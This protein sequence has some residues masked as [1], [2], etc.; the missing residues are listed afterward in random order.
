MLFFVAFKVTLFLSI[1]HYT[2]IIFPSIHI[3]LKPQPYTIYIMKPK[4]IKAL[5]S[6]KL[7]A[8]PML[9]YAFLNDQMSDIIHVFDIKCHDC[10]FMAKMAHLNSKSGVCVSL[11][12]FWRNAYGPKHHVLYDGRFWVHT[13]HTFLSRSCY[14]YHYVLANINKLIIL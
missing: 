4:Y 3:F 1:K 5:E 7:N 13:R 8:T 14:V 10:V 11:T 2:I 9:M 12:Y 6:N